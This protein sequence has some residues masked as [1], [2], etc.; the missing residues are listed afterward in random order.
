MFLRNAHA[1][2]SSGFFELHD[3]DVV[4]ELLRGGFDVVWMHGYNS[5]THLLVAATQKLRRRPLFVRE[6][7]NVL[8]PRPWWKQMKM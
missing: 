1:T 6:D 8:S 5:L 4:R 7:Q 2:K 3:F